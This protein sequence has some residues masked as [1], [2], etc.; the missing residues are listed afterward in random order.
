MELNG[1]MLNALDYKPT[2]DGVEIAIYGKQQAAKADGHLKF[3]GLDNN[4]P[5]R[6]FLPAEGQKFKADIEAKVGKIIADH[7]TATLTDTDFKDV[8][9]AS[10]LYG[11]LRGVFTDM[12]RAE[13]QLAVLRSDSLV[14][15]LQ[16]M[17]LMDLL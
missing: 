2:K 17:D 6:R 14:R 16:D 8:E 11:V 4:T 1:D 9:T 5:Q 15:I 7:M 12:T 3:S 10:D 13:I